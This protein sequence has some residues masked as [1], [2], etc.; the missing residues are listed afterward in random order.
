M[1]TEWTNEQMIEAWRIVAGEARDRGLVTEIPSPPWSEAEVAKLY[2]QFKDS[3]GGQIVDYPSLEAFRQDFESWALETRGAVAMGD[4]VNL[5]V[6][7]TRHYGPVSVEFRLSRD[8]R[9]LGTNGLTAAMRQLNDAVN[10]IARTWERENV[11]GVAA[12]NVPRPA[13]NDRSERIQGELVHLFDGTHKFRL[14]GGQ[15]VQ[16]GVPVYN[17]ELM[18]V[19]IIPDRAPLGELGQYTGLVVFG[20]DGKPKRAVDLAPVNDQPF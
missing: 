6:G 20:A 16:Y 2:A 9:L 13:G 8:F 4:I 3:G 10:D 18:K 7:I 1:R 14:K 12:P 11:R 5:A 19:G 17:E 15:F